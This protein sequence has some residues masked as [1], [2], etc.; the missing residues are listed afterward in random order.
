[1]PFTGYKISDRPSAAT[2]MCVLVAESDQSIV[3]DTGNCMD[4]P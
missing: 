2:Q 4:L 3:P 1:M